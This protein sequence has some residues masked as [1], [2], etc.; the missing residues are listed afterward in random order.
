MATKLS[1]NDVKERL[2]SY[3][4][5]TVTDEL[6]SF[7]T[8]MLHDATDRLA[9]S[10]AKASAIAGYAGALI[11]LLASTATMWL[12]QTHSWQLL[13]PVA[14]IVSFFFAALFAV[15]SMTLK[16]T[17]WFSPNEWMK[18]DCLQS[19][20]RLR[21]YHVL[22]MW[23]ALESLEQC[24]GEKLRDVRRAQCCTLAAWMLLAISFFQIAA[25]PASL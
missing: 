25:F 10:D 7:G 9:K 19:A 15:L 4:E 16:S 12:K 5:S 21:R 2:A 20:E 3:K 13:I 1:V 17:D 22:T 6:Y 8:M 18:A 14:A 11:A 23:G 24:Y